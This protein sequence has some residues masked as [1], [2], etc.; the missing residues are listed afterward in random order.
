M[1]NRLAFEAF[2]HH[3]KD[4]CDNENAFGG[5]LVVLG[6]ISDKYLM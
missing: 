2:N 3:L 4:I 6:Q 1:M 5:T